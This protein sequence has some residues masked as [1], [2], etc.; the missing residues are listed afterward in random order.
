MPLSRLSFYVALAEKINIMKSS[1]NSPGN[2]FTMVMSDNGINVN[3]SDGTLKADSRVKFADQECIIV[4]HKDR[5]SNIVVS[6]VIH[7][8]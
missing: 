3:I 5:L 1:E 8:I 2:K 7:H 6:A 4:S